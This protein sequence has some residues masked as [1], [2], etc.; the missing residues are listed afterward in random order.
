MQT[1]FVSR[2]AA[3]KILRETMLYLFFLVCLGWMLPRV[4]AI[5]WLYVASIS[6]S[7]CCLYEYSYYVALNSRGG[8]VRSTSLLMLEKPRAFLYDEIAS[9]QKYDRLSVINL[10]NG[11]KL[12]IHAKLL[13]GDRYENIMKEI[14]NN[15]TIG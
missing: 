3:R 7:R 10:K 14:T 13:D 9:I 6:F 5:G 1:Y 4:V 2:P 12:K 15:S 8:I 11:S